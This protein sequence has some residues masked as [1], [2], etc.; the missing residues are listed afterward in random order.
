MYWDGFTTMEHD[1]RA[2]VGDPRWTLL[3]PVTRAHTLAQRA[4]VTPD[5]VRWLFGA[6]ARWY[7][8]DRV[9]GRWHLSAPPSHP[10]VR[11]GA[12]PSPPSVAIPPALIP[13]GPDFAYDRGSTQGFVGPDVPHEITERLRALLLAHRGLRR[14]DFP[15]G[16]SVYQQI[17]ARDVAATVAAVWGTIMWCAYAPAFDG[18]EVMLSMFGEFLARPLPGD[19]WVRWLPMGSLDA[20]VALYAERMR[21]GAREAGLRLAGLMTETATVLRADPRFRPRADALIA[22]AEPLLGS[23]WLD[24]HALPG[25]AVRQAWLSR[26]PPHLVPATLPEWAPGEHFRHTL[27][28]LVEALDYTAARGMDPRAMAAAL[29]AADVAGVCGVSEP[30]WAAPG[31]SRTA[32]VVAAL[33][34]WM[35]DELRQAL[36]LALAEP[37]HPLRGCWPAGGELPPG[38]VPPDRETAAALLGS[39]YATGL[40]WCA[41]TA[42]PAPPEGFAVCSAVVKCLIHQRDDPRPRE[43]AEPRRPDLDES[44]GWLFETSNSDISSLPPL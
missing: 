1:V 19:D 41:L 22:M 29:L 6:H 4:L 8:L 5:G 12:R 17:F 14:E 37:T 25:G 2:V 13:A 39:A 15:L 7:R 23:P 18:N 40:A 26:C 11:S 33:Y 31:G 9:D 38:L 27:Y 34:P 44:G 21:S 10:A 32:Q 42:T 43:A 24:Q 3:P 30:A 28:D 35:D 16:G 36:Y 20:L